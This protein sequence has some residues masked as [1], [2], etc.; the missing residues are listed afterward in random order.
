MEL[1]K[2]TSLDVIA[3]SGQNEAYDT[4][5]VVIDMF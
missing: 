3:T 4:E 1:I 5:E 2:M